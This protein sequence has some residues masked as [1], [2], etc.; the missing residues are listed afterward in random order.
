M[1]EVLPFDMIVSILQQ[2]RT[3]DQYRCRAVCILW[4]KALDVSMRTICCHY[5]L[6][7]LS[8]VHCHRPTKLKLFGF[9][10][11]VPVW[12]LIRADILLTLEV[13][14]DG[15][16]P[17]E[18]LQ[19]TLSLC[20]S[21]RFL[22]AWPYSSTARAWS[23]VKAHPTVDAS[24]SLCWHDNQD[25]ALVEFLS[26][27]PSAVRITTLSSILEQVQCTSLWFV[28]H[29]AIAGLLPD[30]FPLLAACS[31][32]THLDV[33]FLS[34]GGSS[35]IQLLRSNPSLR[36]VRLVQLFVET[37]EYEE[38]CLYELLTD[39]MDVFSPRSLKSLSILSRSLALLHRIDFADFFHTLCESVGPQ[40][41]FLQLPC[42]LQEEHL[43]KRPRLDGMLES[44]RFHIEF[45]ERVPTYFGILPFDIYVDSFTRS[46]R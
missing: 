18:E 16:L 46:S 7:G 5:A 35:L 2:L 23:V 43:R 6:S 28:R 22:T 25:D 24:R 14:A 29:L 42:Y 36:V 9:P 3:R 11:T 40:F 44:R 10:S 1:N 12:N 33:G 27:E 26:M 45:V 15:P 17:D 37:E 32:I 39:N 13:H 41:E 4:Q 31:A 21:L 38:E 34:C 19:L 30:H 20:C 8:V